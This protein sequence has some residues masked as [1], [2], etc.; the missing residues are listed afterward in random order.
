MY[1]VIIYIKIGF[2]VVKLVTAAYNQLF[3][4]AYTTR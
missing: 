2:E 4:F 3:K 1:Y